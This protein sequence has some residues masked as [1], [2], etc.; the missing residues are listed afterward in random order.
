MV[1]S[2]RVSQW[3]QDD[4]E[5]AVN[6]FD[7][8]FLLALQAAVE[9]ANNNAMPF[10]KEEANLTPQMRSALAVLALYPPMDPEA[11]PQLANTILTDEARIYPF[12]YELL[13]FK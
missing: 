11:K 9:G 5:A 3:L 6:N 2:T 8:D 12:Y 1:F 7:E 13:F 10:T 4:I